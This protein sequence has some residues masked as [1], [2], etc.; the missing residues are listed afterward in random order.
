MN[1]Q[2]DIILPEDDGSTSAKRQPRAFKIKLKKVNEINM[3]E[4]QRFL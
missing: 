3:E 1:L 4:L 2:F